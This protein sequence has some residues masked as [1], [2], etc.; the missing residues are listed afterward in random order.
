MQLCR[1]GYGGVFGGRQKE[2][3]DYAYL[4]TS[5]DLFDALKFAN[6]DPALTIKNNKVPTVMIIET[7]SGRLVGYHSQFEGEEE[8]LISHQVGPL[9]I[10]RAFMARA[11][12]T[13]EDDPEILFLFVREP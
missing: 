8:V 3:L 7:A 6:M 10:Q 5:L 11:R 9:K 4:S 13:S 2:F 12:R 1:S